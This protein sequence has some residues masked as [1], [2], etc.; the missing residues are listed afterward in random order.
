MET[1]RTAAPP[2][3]QHSPEE[4]LRHFCATHT[5]QEAQFR[6]WQW[7]VQAVQASFSV[8]C[9]AHT[10]SLVAL[11][12]ELDL[13]LEDLYATFYALQPALGQHPPAAQPQPARLS[14]RLWVLLICPPE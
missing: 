5:L 4:V 6:L 10:N 13:A 8:C 9:P 14:P 3:T 1:I 7:F 12:E 2:P 11:Y